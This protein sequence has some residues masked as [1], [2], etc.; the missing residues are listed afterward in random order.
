MENVAGAASSGGGGEMALE[1][2]SAMIEFAPVGLVVLDGNR[3]LKRVNKIAA[4]ASRYS[5]CTSRG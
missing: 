2:V 3:R 5:G 1:E 4:E